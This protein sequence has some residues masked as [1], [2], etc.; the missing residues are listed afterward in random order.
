[1]PYSTDEIA[2]GA[3]TT[4][5]GVRL[6]ERAGMFGDVPRNDQGHRVFSEAHMKRARII[7]AAQMAGLDLARI[8]VAKDAHLWEDINRAAIFMSEV[9]SEIFNEDFD[10]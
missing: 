3:R 6:W 4:L 5:R 7:S 10:L 8:Q 9:R 2:K 1:M